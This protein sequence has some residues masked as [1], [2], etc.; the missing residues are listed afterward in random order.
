MSNTNNDAR[1]VLG[2]GL[3]ALSIWDTVTLAY[4]GFGEYL[5][6]DKFEIK[7]NFEEK[8]SESKSHRDYGQARASVV[9]PKP[10]EITIELA[11]ASTEALAMQFQGMVAKLTQAAG[12]Q[13]ETD[14]A[15]TVL[16]RW[17]SLGHREIIGAGFKVEKPTAGEYELDVDYEVNWARGE[18]R[19]L[20]GSPS[21]PTVA[22][23]VKVTCSWAAVDGKRILGGRVTQVRC[24]ARFDGVNMVDH[25]PLEAD[26]WE[27]VLG[28]DS[29]FD[30]LASEFSS[31][32]LKGKL[33]TPRGKESPYEVRRPTAKN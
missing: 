9:V 24:Q 20:S 32:T 33:V 16:D 12:Q 21:A 27:C 23:T 29:G 13:S 7:P 22:T 2:A 15:V 1:A 14:F 6:A 4:T 18:I 11:A 31:I 10:T 19:F 8:T 30:F 17:I 5:D 26:V 3:V 25:S 28:A